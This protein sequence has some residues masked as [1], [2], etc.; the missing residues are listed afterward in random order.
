MRWADTTAVYDKELVM[1]LN[2]VLPRLHS[3]SAENSVSGLYQLMLSFD[4]L[5]S[6]QTTFWGGGVFLYKDKSVCQGCQ[7]LERDLL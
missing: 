2:T 1:N 5:I 4:F 3:I 6:I 7:V